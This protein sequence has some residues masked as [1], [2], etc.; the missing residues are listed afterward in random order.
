MLPPS[1]SFNLKHNKVIHEKIIILSVQFDPVP[2]VDLL[3][4]FKITTLDERITLLILHY[5]YMDTTDIPKAIERLNEKEVVIDLD[6]ATYFLGRETVVITKGTG[7]SPLRESLFDFLG[8][9]SPGFPNI[10]ICLRRKF[11]K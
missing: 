3:K 2:H 6:N 1:L 4:H 9:K 8:R 11:L 7:M 10:L 5:G